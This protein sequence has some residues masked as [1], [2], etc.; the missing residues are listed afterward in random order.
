[1]KGLP[2]LADTAD[3]Y[4]LQRHG[5]DA[6]TQAGGFRFGYGNVIC[7]WTFVPAILIFSV[8][9]GVSLYEGCLPVKDL[10]FNPDTVKIPCSVC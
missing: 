7:F 3:K 6:V 10:F 4:E 8:G 1:M 5:V 9:S 2:N